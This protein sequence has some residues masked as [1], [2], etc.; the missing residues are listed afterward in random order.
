VLSNS[1]FT[2]GRA[3]AKM[4][5]AKGLRNVIDAMRPMMNHFLLEV[6]FLRIVI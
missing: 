4:D 1:S 2:K 5:E 3:G 6:K